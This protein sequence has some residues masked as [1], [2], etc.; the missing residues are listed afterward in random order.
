[1]RGGAGCELCEAAR[2]TTWYHEDE[3][4]WVADCEVCGVPM[5]V[6]RTHGADPPDEAH[7][8]MVEQL[9]RVADGV[10][11]AGR[12]SLDAVMRQIPDHFHAHARD[13]DWWFRRI[14]RR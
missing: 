14:G 6:W 2:L 3:V 11:G 8:H 12:W 9:T 1:V 13:P 5:V 7:A 4:C 10:L